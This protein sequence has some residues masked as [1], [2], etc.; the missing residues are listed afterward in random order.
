MVGSI[1]ALLAGCFFLGILHGIIPDEHTWPI[2]FSYSVGSAS[3]RGGMLAAFFF[4]S[5][6]TLQRTLMSGFAYFAIVSVVDLAKYLGYVY[7]AV[8]TAMS[9]AGFLIMRN[10]LPHWH[11]LMWISNKDRMKHEREMDNR[12]VP[13]HWTIIHGFI[14]G[15]GVDTG[16][17][18]S[19][20]YL[21]AVPA[22]PNPFLGL[23]PGLLFGFGTM[24]IL[25]VIGLIFGSGLKI[26]KRFGVERIETFGS[27]VA[28]RS[29]FAGGLLFVGAG[30]F[31]ISPMAGIINFDIGDLLVISFMILIVIPVVLKSWNDARR[32]KV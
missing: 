3:G 16:L 2:T 17:F 12:L 8:G 4:S 15:F 23:A 21:V 29:L 32:I 31:E 1:L 20:I 5:A 22:M 11:P 10:S 7:V 25:L 30:S 13:V 27:M 9:L 19:F 26:A 28:S 6:F 14:A 18:T 24:S